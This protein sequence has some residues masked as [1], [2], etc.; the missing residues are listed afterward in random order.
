MQNAKKLLSYLQSNLG[1]EW[2]NDKLLSEIKKFSKAEDVSFK[3]IF[4]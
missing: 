4:S 2:K 3:K 1:S